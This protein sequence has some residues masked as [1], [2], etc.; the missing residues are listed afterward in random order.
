MYN[1][2]KDNFMQTKQILAVAVAAMMVTACNQPMG[3]AGQG[4]TQ[5]GSSVNKQ[6][7]GTAAGAIGGAVAGYQ[8]GKGSGK[9]AATVAGALLG[10]LLGSNLGASLD[11]ADMQYY[12]AT[13][14]RALE[15]GQTGQSFPWKNPQTGNY[16]S[17][18]PSSYYEKD[19]R[20]CREYT[21]T[22]TVGGKTQQGHGTAC[23]QE[24][25]SWQI[26]N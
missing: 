18:T 6:D 14:N 9:A 20:Y 7:V 8:F 16:G 1:I 4:V 19:G 25:G 10:G 17:V 23:R 5:G 13:A 15:N 26:V 2:K 24:D 11:R 22:I 12:D 21:Q 3:R